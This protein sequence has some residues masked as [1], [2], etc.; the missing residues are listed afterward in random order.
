MTRIGIARCWS[1]AVGL[2][3]T[4]TGLLLVFVPA[5]TLRLMGVPAIPDKSLVFLSWMGVFIAGV[6][7]SYWLVLRG[8]REA[9]TVWIFTATVRFLVTLF[10]AWKITAGDLPAIWMLVAI[11]DGVVAAGQWAML[12]AGFWKGDRP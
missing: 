2:M 6:G 12:R 10:L 3:D 5:V 11:T 8:R 1:L 7:M 4:L 9:E